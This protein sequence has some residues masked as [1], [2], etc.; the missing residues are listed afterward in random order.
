MNE[1]SIYSYSFDNISDNFI[2]ILVLFHFI[3]RKTFEIDS[4]IARNS[5]RSWLGQFEDGN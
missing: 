2:E 5:K 4:I 1:R 3:I